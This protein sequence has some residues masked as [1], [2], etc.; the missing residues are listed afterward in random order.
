MANALNVKIGGDIRELE[1]AL[2]QASSKIKSAGKSMMSVGKTLS[3]SVTAPLTALGIASLKTA[4]DFETLQQSM[5]VLNG[6]VEEGSRNFERLKEFSAGTP[7]QLQDLAKAQNMLQ[8]FGLSA[9]EAFD[10]LSMIGD[11]SAISGGSIE[12]IGVAFGQAAAEGRL[13][14]RDIRQLINQGVPAIKLLS[15]TMGVAESE[16]FDLASQ[17]EISFETLQKSFREATQEGGMF[18]NGMAQQ[19]QTLNGLFSTLKDNI[20]IAMAEIGNSMAEAMNLREIVPAMIERIKQVTS[21]FKNL[22]T[23]ART[24]IVNIVRAIATIG[25]ALIAVGA[26]VTALGVTISLLTS[27]ITLVIA[28]I[29]GLAAAITYVWDNWEAII[30]RVS[31]I[32]WWRNTLIEMAQ[33]LIEWSAPSLFIKGINKLIEY[34][35]DTDWFKNG[36]ILMGRL[37]LEYNPFALLIK[38]ANALLEFLNQDLIDPVEG[39]NEELKKTGAIPN[40]YEGLADSLEYLKV[41]QKE[42]NHELGS[43]KDAVLN[44]GKAVTGIDFRNM[45]QPVEQGAEDADVAIASIGNTVKKVGVDMSLFEKVAVPSMQRAT[46]KISNGIAFANQIAND[47]TNSFGS[48]MANVVVQGEKLADTLKNIGK[49]LASSIIQKG[50]S[51]FLTGGLGGS[52]FFGSGGGLFGKIFGVNDALITSGGDVVK[53]NSADDILASKNMDKVIGG[54]GGGRVEVFGTLRGQDLFISSDRGGKTFDR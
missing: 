10:S 37:V 35:Q 16:I 22:S 20:S 3:A 2:N 24:S 30:E 21:W 49:L 23:E 34:W 12:G 9:D 18:A 7:F 47:F 6:S 25:P 40:P 39:F 45:L 33:F 13:M 38:A 4:A 53:F 50:L 43:F 36:L 28:S 32:G 5:N 11:I 51:A 41:Q 54:G 8:G 26:T 15:E 44:A 14:S 17:G 27:P 29:A 19:S 1:K 31:D 42:Y 52:G 46:K 48:G